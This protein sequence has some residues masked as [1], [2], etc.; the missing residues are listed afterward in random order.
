MSIDW[1]NI[2][3]GLTGPFPEVGS[4]PPDIEMFKK[5]FNP[6]DL[7]QFSKLTTEIY[8]FVDKDTKKTYTKEKHWIVEYGEVSLKDA[9][10]AIKKGAS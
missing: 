2:I 5:K 7:G 1:E 4:N 9:Q 8:F 3:N 6:D 10:E